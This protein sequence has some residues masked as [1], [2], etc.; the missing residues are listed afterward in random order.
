MQE[1]HSSAQTHTHIHQTLLIYAGYLWQ[2]IPL[3]T[4]SHRLPLT[5]H[6]S[7][8]KATSYSHMGSLLSSSLTDGKEKHRKFKRPFVGSLGQ[9]VCLW[10]LSEQFAEEMG[11]VNTREALFS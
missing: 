5:A 11:N 10:V 2:S 4:G 6:T 8:R 3:E 7:S 9:F 1:V